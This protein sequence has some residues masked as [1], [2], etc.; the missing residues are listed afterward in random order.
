MNRI[1]ETELILPTLLMMSLNGGI[2][3]TSELI[4]KLRDILNP[5]GEDLKIL[6]GRND[7]KFSQKVRNLTAHRTLERYDYAKYELELKAHKITQKGTDYLQSN[8]EALSYI[9][10]NNFQ[11]T[12]IVADLSNIT[13]NT[14]KDD[15]IKVEQFE[16]DIF[17]NEGMQKFVKS[18]TYERSNKLRKYA[19]EHFADN[20]VVGCNA[21]NF[22][23]EKFYG[24]NLGEG[25]I[26][27]HH[28]KPVYQYE[29]EDVNKTI[30]DALKNLTPLCSNCHKMV[31]RKRNIILDVSFLKSE[32]EKT[33]SKIVFGQQNL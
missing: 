4:I 31:H 21:C 5:Q 32:I 26:E 19:I 15:K 20:G 24:K 1:S 13:Q 8:L 17:I 22:V 28:I 7:D 14:S 29:G 3:T 18:K 9:L 25:F 33:G 16:E 12:D 23:F 27:I 11:Y 2:I 6:D 30:S 10:S